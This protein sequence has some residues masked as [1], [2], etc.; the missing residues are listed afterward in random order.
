MIGSSSGR[1]KAQKIDNAPRGFGRTA[2]DQNE[3]ALAWQ[4]Y[5]LSGSKTGAIARSGRHHPVARTLNEKSGH[6]Q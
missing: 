3:V 4:T 2:P 6:L 1:V 5:N